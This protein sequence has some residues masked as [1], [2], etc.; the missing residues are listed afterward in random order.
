MSPECEKDL[1]WF[2]C[3]GKEGI[4]KEKEEEQDVV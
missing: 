3:K 4:I 1:L 2:D